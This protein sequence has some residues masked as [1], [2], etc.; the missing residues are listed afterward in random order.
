MNRVLIT[1]TSGLIGRW[2]AD[3]MHKEGWVVHGYDIRPAPEEREA[4]HA[5]EADLL[6]AKSVQACFDRFKPDAVI[7]LAARTDLNGKTLE[8]YAVNTTALDILCDVIGKS[9]SVKRAIYTSSQL[10]CPVGTIPDN[11][12][13]FRPNTVYGSS[14]VQTEVR[15]RSANGGGVEWCI[16]R[17]TTVWGPHMSAHYQ[18][19]IKHIQKGTYFHCGSNELWKS[20]SYVENIATQYSRMLS[21]PAELIDQKVFY[22]ADYEPLSLRD[23]ANLI[24]EELGVRKPPTMPIVAAKCLAKIGDGIGAAGFNFPFNSFRLRNIRTEYVFDLSNT[25]AVCGP[26]PV[27]FEEG[28]RRTIDWYKNAN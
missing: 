23:Y 8:D 13:D 3:L 20:Y 21:A 22:L 28:V 15:V 16:T 18:S 7:H 6:D 11:D 17:P 10:V 14:K 2:T 26:V 12:L 24:A 27:G 5:D 4:W 9:S 25:E 1:G 19:L